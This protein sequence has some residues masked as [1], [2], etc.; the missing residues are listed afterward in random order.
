[1]IGMKRKGMSIV[2][3]YV[4]MIPEEGSVSLSLI[5]LGNLHAEDLLGQLPST[6]GALTS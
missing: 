3:F 6:A 4:T 1:M 2:I 5:A